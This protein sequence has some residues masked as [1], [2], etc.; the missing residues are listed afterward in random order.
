M[1]CKA[2]KNG[3]LDRVL[4]KCFIIIIIIITCISFFTTF[5]KAEI[6]A[7]IRKRV[8]LEE[9]AFRLVEKLLESPISKEFLIEAVCII[10][11]NL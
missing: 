9:K 4:Y 10:T 11:C 2:P 3:L 5:R 7:R 1:F 8:A 6:E